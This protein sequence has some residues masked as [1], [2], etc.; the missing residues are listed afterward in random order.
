MGRCASVVSC[1]TVAALDT[2]TLRIPRCYPSGTH[3]HLVRC[4][5]KQMHLSSQ[6]LSHAS[7]LNCPSVE[8]LKV[9]VL[10]ELTVTEG[11]FARF[12]ALQWITQ[13]Q[14]GEHVVDMHIAIIAI[15]K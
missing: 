5:A 6:R 9:S 2:V 7:H 4:D 8:H 15:A 13:A 1:H 11:R 10:V 12:L 3:E 14:A